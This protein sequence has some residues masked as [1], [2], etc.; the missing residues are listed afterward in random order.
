MAVKI[1]LEGSGT[2]IYRRIINGMARSLKKKRHQTIT[3]E[4]GREP[5][6]EFV[7]RV[8]ELKPDLVIISNLFGALS[9]YSPG[10][11]KYIY[12]LL[13]SPAV[14]LHYDNL[15]GPIGDVSEIKRRLNTLVSIS[16]RSS[17]FFI[18]NN[19]GSDFQKL[20]VQ[21][22]HKMYHASEFDLIENNGKYRY[23]VSFVGQ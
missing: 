18:E 7:R 3:V 16:G 9:A 1:F 4:P 11:K 19:I 2:P 5:P 15:L 6:L 12:E 13:D 10:E 22:A 21:N 8:N 23:G 17:H 20:S 14:F